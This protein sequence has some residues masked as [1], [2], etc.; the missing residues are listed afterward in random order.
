MISGERWQK[1]GEAERAPYQKMADDDK[2][3]YT[4]ELEAF[5]MNKMMMMNGK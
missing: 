3:R 1:M 2:V 4:Q 5:R